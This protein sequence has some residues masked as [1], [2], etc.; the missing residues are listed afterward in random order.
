M[1]E[2]EHYVEQARLFSRLAAEARSHAERDGFTS[3]AAGYLALAK[4]AARHELGQVPA[5]ESE[6]A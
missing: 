3:V 1:R 2:T 4:R 6:D 5:P